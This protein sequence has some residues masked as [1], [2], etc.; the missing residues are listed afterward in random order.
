MLL[1]LKVNRH[2][3][4]ELQL[5]LFC[6]AFPSSIWR[7]IGTKLVG[8]QTFY[9]T[10]IY[11]RFALHITKHPIYLYQLGVNSSS[12]P[13]SSNTTQINFCHLEKVIVDLGHFDIWC[14]I[15]RVIAIGVNNFCPASA[16][17]YTN[18]LV[19]ATRLSIEARWFSDRY[20]K[21]EWCFSCIA[22]GA[23][24]ELRSAINLSW[25]QGLGWNCRKWGTGRSQNVVPSFNLS[26]RMTAYVL[27]I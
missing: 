4:L 11:K 14:F 6:I 25:E 13:Y 15:F 18:V 17:C 24:A 20:W 8:S 9:R 5:L 10:C 7:N 26:V 2:V 27:M 19:F 3:F 21:G 1:E 23:D 22:F 12:L 16:L